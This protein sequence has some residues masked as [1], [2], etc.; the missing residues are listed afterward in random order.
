MPAVQ[1]DWK[2]VG[3][4]AELQQNDVQVAY[5]EYEVH[6]FQV[7]DAGW[8]SSD[9]IDYLDLSRSDIGGQNYG[10]YASPAFDSELR[11]AWGSADPAVTALHARKAE[12]ILLDD[13]PVAPIYFPASHNLVNPALTG[14]IDNPLDVHGAHW[15]CRAP[16]APPDVGATAS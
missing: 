12:Q 8:Q 2:Q 1:S 11:A 4:L 14:W 10:D 15:L 7:G 5:Q 6:D 13:A 9:A 16:A 3:V